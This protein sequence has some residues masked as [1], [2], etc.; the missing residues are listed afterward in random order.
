M[1]VAIVTSVLG[2]TSVGAHDPSKHAGKSE[3]PNCSAMHDTQNDMAASEDPVYQAMIMQ[4]DKT[5]DEHDESDGHGDGMQ[6]SETDGSKEVK[7]ADHEEH[8][9]G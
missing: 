4:C 6:H 2:A 9:N 8:G 1:A 7:E 3:K 5:Y